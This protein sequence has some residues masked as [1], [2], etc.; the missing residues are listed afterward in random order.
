MGERRRHRDIAL[1]AAAGCCLSQH[2]AVAAD[3]P[4]ADP[5]VVI[6]HRDNPVSNLSSAELRNFFTRRERRWPAGGTVLPVN[7]KALSGPRR[8]FD[9]RILQ[10]TPEQAATF[11]IDARIR[12]GE[13]P[14]LSVGS[15]RLIARFVAHQRHAISYVPASMLSD[16]V[17]RVRVDGLLPG[18]H[19][20]PLR[21]K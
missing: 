13:R 12:G 6:V 15:A 20:Y 21:A 9:K 3:R 1:V 2:G 11:W 4:D 5:L 7:W 17:K 18:D 14:P 10:M 16:E 8:R 19:K